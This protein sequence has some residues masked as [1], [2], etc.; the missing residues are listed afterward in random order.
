M[1]VTP[2]VRV[3]LFLGAAL[4][5]NLAFW[6][7][8]KFIYAKWEGVPP[9]PTRAGA[10]MM[11]LGDQQFSYRLAAITLQNLGDSGGRV[12]P[13]RDYDYA[14]LG[15]W[16]DLLDGLDPASD[17]VPMLAAYYF[18]AT[19]VPADVAVIVDY[20]AKVG[21]RPVG[22]KWRWL[23]HAVFLARHRLGD[24]QVALDLAYKLSK[25]QLQDDVM[26][27]WGRQ[28]PAFVLKAK[29]DREDA[30]KIMVDLL[31]SGKT[32]H[33]NE[34]NFMKAYLIEELGMDAREVDRLTTA[35]PE[36]DVENIRRPRPAPQPE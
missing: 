27:A 33:P 13:I 14:K 19:R 7:G 22:S 1:S 12:T 32:F 3:I 11:A 30:R 5:L 2:K 8:T 28:M 36:T 24:L 31:A 29:G 10:T 6:A 17:H 4:A 18:G 23:V 9:V 34:I 16:F 15:A 35:R 25:M 26:P 21:E 20:L